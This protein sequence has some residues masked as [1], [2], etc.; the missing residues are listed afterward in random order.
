MT[1]YRIEIDAYQWWGNIA[2]APDWVTRPTPPYRTRVDVEG[3]LNVYP[4]STVNGAFAVFPGEVICR[5]PD[6]TL[7]RETS[8]EFLKNYRPVEEKVDVSTEMG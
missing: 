2:G 1:K 5:R 7:Y 3:K 4:D 6:G 8:E